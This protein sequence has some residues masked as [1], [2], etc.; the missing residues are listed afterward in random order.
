M[1]RLADVILQR[2]FLPVKL[3]A[4]LIVAPPGVVAPAFSLGRFGLTLKRVWQ[5]G[6][7]ELPCSSP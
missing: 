4:G 2:V 3:P 6:S 1:Q 5:V 7:G